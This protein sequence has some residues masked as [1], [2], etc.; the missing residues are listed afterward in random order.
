MSLKAILL[1]AGA[2]L[3]HT[4]HSRDTVRGC[5]APEP[6]DELL[7]VSREFAK[8]EA[9]VENSFS[10][11]AAISVPV[12]LHSVASSQSTVLSDATLQNQFNVLR[13]DFAPSGV[14]LRLAGT[15]KTV[16]PTWSRDRGEMEMKRALRKGD[17]GTLNIYLQDDLG[18]NLGYCYFPT[19]A[20]SGSTAF[21]RDGCSVLASSVPGGS[22]TGF[23]L[24]KTATHE[25]GHWFGLYHTF[26]GGCTSTNDGVADT[27]AQSSPSSGCPIGRDSCPNLPGIDPIHNY[28][29]YSQDSCYEEFTA[30]QAA[31]ISSFWNAYR[32]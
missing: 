7:Q 30:G 28:M 4:I 19:N 32:A 18:G 8:Q 2:A 1:F 23:N 21:V 24:G 31:R 20:P 14:N 29:D 9:D 25:A 16:N 17:Y 13:N 3:G 22:A 26:Q 6:S 5:G 27:P 11:Q 15:T 10:A 12:Y